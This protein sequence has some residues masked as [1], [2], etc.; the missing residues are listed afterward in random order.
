MLKV[1][2]K[3]KN[4][5]KKLSSI[6]AGFVAAAML[7]SVSA[8]TAIVYA[9]SLQDQINQLS[10]QNNQTQAQRNVLSDEATS[11]EDKVSKLAAQIDTYQRQINDNETK[12]TDLKNKIAE[13][14]AELIKQKSLLGENI[15]AMYVEGDISTIEMLASSKNLSEFV[16]KQQYRNA[17]KSKIVTTLEKITQL[18]QQLN[19]ES[20]TLGLRVE[21]QKR[22]QTELDGQ[23]AEQNG[24]LG[25]N[26]AQRVD[27]DSQIKGNNKKIEE[28]KR[29]QA[30][31]NAR[32]FGGTGGVL[33]GGGYPWGSA[34]CAH[35]GQVDGPCW[36]YDWSV[37][38]SIWNYQTGGYGYRNCTD[39]VA[40]RIASTRGFVPSGL[41]NAKDWPR[42]AQARGIAVDRT[43]RPG[44][45]AVSTAG[46]YG[47]VMYV[48]AV[49]ANGTI[50]VSDYNRAGTGKYDSNSISPNGLYFVHF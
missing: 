26:S 50:L 25:L 10:Q 11:L 40:F 2:M 22:N 32:L 6:S 43:P 13:K 8:P 48:E 35:T 24:L 7:V 42:N 17:V 36:N 37:G 9:Q 19:A 28:L 12:I 21:D 45:A 3:N 34:V 31:E 30:A 44:A 39:W 47:H 18:K 5:I 20:D 33:G 14:E 49:N 38:G 46:F 4:T 29:Q 41:G 27:L 15:K 16:D 23:R 1:I